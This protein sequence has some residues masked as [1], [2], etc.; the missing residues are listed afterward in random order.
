MIKSKLGKF[1]KEE[2]DFVYNKLSHDE[3][4]KMYVYIFPG[5]TSKDDFEELIKINDLKKK[6]EADGKYWI[7]VNNSLELKNHFLQQIKHIN[8]DKKEQTNF[9]SC[10]SDGQLYM[11]ILLTINLL[12]SKEECS[13][14]NNCI[15]YKSLYQKLEKNITRKIL[16][17]H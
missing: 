5:D 15:K 14:Y 10:K 6:L 13:E 17:V 7:P 9:L 11:K 1:T 16:I 12:I 3:I 2:F 8:N 4:K